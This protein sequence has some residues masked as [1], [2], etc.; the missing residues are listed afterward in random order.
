LA[1]RVPRDDDLM[2]AFNLFRIIGGAC[3]FGPGDRVALTREQI[4]PRIARLSPLSGK[5]E[6][7]RL[8]CAVEES[9]EFK[10]GEVI[11]FVEDFDELPRAISSLL[12]P[13]D[14]PRSA[15]TIRSEPK[16]PPPKSEVSSARESDETSASS[17]ADSGSSTRTA[18][19]ADAA[20]AADSLAST[21]AGE[22][23]A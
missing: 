22:G 2:S 18:Q 1:A 14:P 3:R 20:A 4:E 6:K 16:S 21:H 10:I 15:A 9:I 13:I 12:E 19:E 17:N 7:R 8:L 5:A 11:G 23:G